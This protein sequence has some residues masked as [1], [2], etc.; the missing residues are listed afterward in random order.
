[1][2][3]KGHGIWR[4]FSGQPRKA[5]RVVTLVVGINDSHHDQL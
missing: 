1:M 5:G 3:N 4:K 2:Q